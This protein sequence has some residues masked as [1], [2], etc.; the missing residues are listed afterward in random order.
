MGLNVNLLLTPDLNVV[1]VLT[2]VIVV[3]V[4]IV[5]NIVCVLL[6]GNTAQ[7]IS[8]AEKMTL[9]VSGYEKIERKTRK[10]ER[11]RKATS[12]SE[13]RGGHI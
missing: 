1:Q 6:L 13:L 11:L 4:V 10:G 8:N 12:K 5:V 7:Y 2:I 3:V 9:I